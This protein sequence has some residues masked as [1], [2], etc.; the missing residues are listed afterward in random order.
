M[1]NNK[2][3]KSLQYNISLMFDMFSE[4]V[5][6]FVE[7][8]FFLKKKNNFD[9]RKTR[10]L[11]ETRLLVHVHLCENKSFFTQTQGCPIV[12]VSLRENV[13]QRVSNIFVFI[14]ILK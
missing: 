11:S 7:V 2:I 13:L 9:L 1:K 5:H 14:F 8:W 12:S 6:T 10:L 4:N 3:K